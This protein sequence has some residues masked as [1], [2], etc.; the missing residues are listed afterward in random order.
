MEEESATLSRSPSNAE[1]EEKEKERERGASRPKK[2][3]LYI[4]K[5]KG[6]L[7][8]MVLFLTLKILKNYYIFK[9]GTV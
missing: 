8:M 7:T 1:R 6:R 2:R 3:E 4:K 5:R 9:V